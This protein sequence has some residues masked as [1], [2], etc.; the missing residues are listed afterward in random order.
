M[1]IAAGMKP[2]KT[3]PFS[4]T[5]TRKL[6]SMHRSV[7]RTFHSTKKLL[8]KLTLLVKRSSVFS[9]SIW[10][11]ASAKVAKLAKQNNTDM[12]TLTNS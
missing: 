3:Q 6:N 11:D 4:S 7:W 2:N 9:F 1:F 8:L 12:V 10:C 5:T